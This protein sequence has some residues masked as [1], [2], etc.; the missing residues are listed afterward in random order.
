MPE[1][2]KVRTFGAAPVFLTAISTIL[3]AVMF[4]RFGYAVGNVGFYGTLA[5]VII[6]HLVTIPTAMALS[7]IA[8]NQKV[9]G[10]GEYYIISRSFGIN[11]GAAIGIALFFSQAISVAFYLIAFAEAFDPV[12]D[13]VMEQYGFLIDKRFISLPMLGVMFLLMMGKGADL[14]VKALYVVVGL[15]F[16]S[17]VLFFIGSPTHGIEFTPSM[18]ASKVENPDSFFYVFAICFPAFTG[19]TA[20]VGLSGDLKD[21][22]RSIPLGT[23]SATVVG[24]LVY[25]FIAFKLSISATPEELDSDQLIMGNISVWGPIIPIGLAAATVSSALGSIMVAPRTLQALAGDSV[26]PVATVNK[27]LHKGKPITNEPVHATIVTTLIALLFIALGDINAVAEIISMF[28]MVTY[29]SICAIS[30]LQHFAANPSYRPIF[31]SK[32]FLSLLGAVLC[33]YLMFMMNP[34]YAV[35]AL[36]IMTLFYITITYD[37]NRKEGLA[38][39]FQGVIFQLSRQLQVF[40][41]MSDKNTKDV[42][43]RPS[44]ICMCDNSFER[45][46]A[47]NLMRWMS[48]QYGFGT[49]IHFINGYYSKETKKD[50]ADALERLIGMA[51]ASHSNVY[52]DTLISPSWTSA[53]AQLVQLPGISGT[54]NNMLLFEFKKG[55]AGNLPNVV[56]NVNIMST[57]GFDVCILGS[58]DRAFGFNRE[59]HIWLGIHDFTNASLMI[60][61]GYIILGHPD[62]SNGQIKLFALFPDD[63]MHSQQTNLHDLVESGRIPISASNINVL[64]YQENMAFSSVVSEHS[65]K[66]DL[67]I[68]GF[69]AKYMKEKYLDFFNEFDKVGNV[70]FVS[71]QTEKVIS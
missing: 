53:I 41:Q 32:W 4:L 66:A 43:W 27:W 61:L 7:E 29:G 12:R 11:I 44:V 35:L 20:G 54:E 25:V 30:F 46:Q 15:L 22:S 8:T 57:A 17:L 60:L 51:G 67:T 70:L 37:T 19:V 21:P 64:G 10:G 56:D 31:R 52:L 23:L 42:S 65:S 68:I 58:S 34:G 28:F 39:I 49:Y 33:V 62:W 71:A 1:P 14:G 50:A 6:G 55:E 13:M 69:N 16:V 45:F 18:L 9:E 36:I 26:F 24:M 5:I 3:G 59:I 63:E 38:G 2:Q 47:F 48:H 40:L